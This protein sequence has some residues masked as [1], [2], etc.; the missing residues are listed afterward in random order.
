MPKTVLQLSEDATRLT[1]D[2]DL[3]LST[4]ATLFDDAPRFGKKLR[5]IDLQKV[6]DS[7][8]AGLALL[9]HWSHEAKRAT[10][11]T[12]QLQFT[13]AP[14]RLRKLAKVAGVDDLFV[15]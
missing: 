14:P 6:D 3:N 7:D 15:K 10:G 8:S 5:S 9:L 13:H 1:I 11:D 2:G 12:T 4:A